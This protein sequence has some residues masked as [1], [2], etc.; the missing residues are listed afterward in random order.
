MIGQVSRG[1]ATALRL[2]R[3]DPAPSGTV[4][5][6]DA[7]NEVERPGSDLVT[8]FQAL[9]SRVPVGCRE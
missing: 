2:Q 7:I 5:L 9:L 3:G 6:L 4:T 8:P 1:V